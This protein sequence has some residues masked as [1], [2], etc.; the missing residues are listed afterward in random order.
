MNCP[1]CDTEVEKAVFAR[2]ENFLAV[3]NIAPILPGH[4]LIIPGKHI[5]SIL[6]LDE[7]QFSEM[8]QFSRKIT[9]LLL[10]VFRTD[11]FNW[12]VQDK[13]TAGQTVAHMHMHIVLR[14]TG[15]LPDPGDWYPRISHNYDQILDSS[16]RAKLGTKELANIVAQLRSSW[17]IMDYP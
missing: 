4:T 7:Q 15:D 9:R 17:H 12:S 13:E 5:L 2:S 3:Y 11:S 8:M 6:E 1:F 16:N 10:K 14:Y